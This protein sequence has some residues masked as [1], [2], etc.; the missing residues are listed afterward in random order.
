[1]PTPTPTATSASTPAATPAS[2]PAATLASAIQPGAHEVNAIF[3]SR[4]PQPPRA[5]EPLREAI[6]IG[7]G[8]AGSAACER[9]AARGWRVTLI[10]RH[11]AAAQEA[12]GNRAGIFMPLLSKDDNI[13][14]RL[15]R[16]AYLYAMRHWASLGGLLPTAPLGAGDAGDAGASQ[17]QPTGPGP[18]RDPDRPGGAPAQPIAGHACGVLQLARDA[19][20]AELQRQIVAAWNYPP[21]YVRWLDAP[22][23]AG[24]LGA[25]TPHGGWLFGQGGWANPASIC[26]A[27]LDA[28]GTQLT[29]IYNA[30]ALLLERDNGLWQV[31]TAGGALLASAPTLILANG[32]GA[33]AIAQSADLPLYTMRGQVT[34]L[35]ER[36]F[37]RLP[38]VVC[39]EAYMTPPVQGVASVGATYDSDTDPALRPASQRENIERAREILPGALPD[40]PPLAGRVGFRC[41]APD[42]LPLVG[43]LPDHAHASRVE[44]LRDVPR[45]PGL[46]CLLG[47]ASR[48]LIWAPL[49]AELLAARLENEPPPL[50]ATLAAAL[51]PARFLLKSRRKERA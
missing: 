39:R 42:R 35:D 22:E 34:H 32:A 7:A 2:S 13:P 19:D 15:S 38:L 28:C 41:M 40:E 12:S 36:Q 45:H 43:A 10:E 47:Y 4:K 18:S 27:M 17:G 51:D 21:E 44:R 49:A 48:G 16:A 14:T 1:M 5:P 29:R 8:M 26:R 23:A 3:T 24:L 6:V 11:A 46:H 31:R 37:P 30:E 25:P 33:R 9:L 20:H 50:E